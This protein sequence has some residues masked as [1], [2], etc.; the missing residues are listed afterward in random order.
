M[1][2]MRD[3]K[4]DVQREKNFLQETKVVGETTGGVKGKKVLVYFTR[5]PGS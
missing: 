3:A 4:P 5:F 1:E 2:L